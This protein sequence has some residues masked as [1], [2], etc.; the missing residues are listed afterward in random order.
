VPIVDVKAR[1]SS[2]LSESFVPSLL[3]LSDF[4][5]VERS[6]LNGGC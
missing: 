3:V 6:I 2:M 1:W 5:Q 4:L